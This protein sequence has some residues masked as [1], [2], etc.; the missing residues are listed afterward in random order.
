M[1]L[2][3]KDLC[4]S[5]KNK[6]IINNVNVEFESGNIYGIIGGGDKRIFLKLLCS[7][8]APDSGY[9]LQ[10]D[11]NYSKKKEFPKNTRVSLNIENFFEDL[12][13][14]ENLNKIAKIENKI[15]DKDIDSALKN[16]FLFDAIN[17]KF[18][19]YTLDMKNKLSI[20][21]VIMEKPG[22]IILDEPFNYMEQVDIKQIKNVLRELK[23]SG[24]LIIVASYIKDELY[25]LC[26]KVYEFSNGKLVEHLI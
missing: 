15:I 8:C 1:K 21:Q 14:H 25:D 16:V 18:K 11:Y 20:A 23:E 13:G 4:K 9:I 5:I 17:V 22:C 19:K 2:I 10:D 6:K 12:T 26:D 7:F 24:C 3:I